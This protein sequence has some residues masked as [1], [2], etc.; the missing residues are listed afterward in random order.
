V[1]V[2]KTAIL[3]VLAATALTVVL[4]P[5]V[6]LAN[7][8]PHGGYLA[9]TDACAECHRAHTA[10][11]SVTWTDNQGGQKSALLLTGAASM[12]DFCLACH[13]N[14]SQGADTNVLDGL[15]EGTLYGGETT[16]TLLGGP[17][18]RIDPSVG[19]QGALYAPGGMAVTSTH[20]TNG[21]S[22]GAYGGGTF[23]SKSTASQDASGDAVTLLGTGAKIV[24]DCSSCHDPH[25]TSN[26]RLLK[27]VVYGVNVGGYGPGPASLP[28]PFVISREKGFPQGGFALHTKYSGYEPDYTVAKYAV[29]PDGS[30]ASKGMSGWCA[31]CHTTY[32]AKESTY[33]AGDGYG[34]VVR[35]R[36]PINVPMSNFGGPTSVVVTNTLLPFAHIDGFDAGLGT[37]VT[38]NKPGDWIECLTCHNAHG[39]STVMTGWANVADPANDLRVNTG[40]GG[41]P[42]TNDSALLKMDSRG[43]CEACHDK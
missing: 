27:A 23:G 12:E 40:T 37:G 10:P 26:Y 17:F 43:V 14:T 13:D 8:G 34:Y 11:S 19:H 31:G 1:T 42:P 38:D 3:L 2:K 16:T 5:T 9:D 24:M 22:W 32:M 35:H 39:A 6:A 15:Y 21:K 7:M 33:N 18:G 41:T 20:L 4:V 25:G 36:H 28:T 30:D 29:A